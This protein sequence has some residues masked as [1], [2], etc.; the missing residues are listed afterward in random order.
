L[1]V[2]YVNCDLANVIFWDLTC[3]II[4]TTYIKSDPASNVVSGAAIAKTHYNY[5]AALP[6]KIPTR[7]FE[8]QAI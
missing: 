5:D 4:L 7:N 1:N 8:I 3:P 2:S 6:R